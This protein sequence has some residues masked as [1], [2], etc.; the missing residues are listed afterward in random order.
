MSS[1][2]K[3]NVLKIQSK[4]R[5]EIVKKKKN[6]IGPAQHHCLGCAVPGTH[7]DQLGI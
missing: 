6:G 4:N 2:K 5:K 1:F 3:I 7:A